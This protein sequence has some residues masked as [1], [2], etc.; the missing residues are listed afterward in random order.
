MFLLIRTISSYTNA[1]LL[2]GVFTTGEDVRLEKQKYIGRIRANPDSDR[3]KNQAYRP[4]FDLE[5]DL[6]IVSSSK[7]EVQLDDAIPKEVYVVSRMLEAFG[8]VHRELVG[9]YQYKTTAE[10]K[11]DLIDNE[12]DTVSPQY[13]LVEK[14]KVGEALS[15]D[16]QF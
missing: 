9:L 14:A 6:Y 11:A 3:W 8:Q 2:L 4:D 10:E 15:D 5:K 7:I 13:G 16:I 1:D 12:L